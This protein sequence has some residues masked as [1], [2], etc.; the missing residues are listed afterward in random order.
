MSSPEK[1][2]VEEVVKCLEDIY[3]RTLLEKIEELVLDWIKFNE[4]DYDDE[5]DFLHAMEEIE[6]RK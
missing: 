3:G 6:R 4:N 1:Q 2:K 5:V